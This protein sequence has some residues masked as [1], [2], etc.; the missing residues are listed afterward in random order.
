MEPVSQHP[1]EDCNTNSRD[2]TI[3]TSSSNQ[4]LAFI[5]DVKLTAENFTIIGKQITWLILDK[6]IADEWKQ[7]L[8][9]VADLREV[10]EL[11]ITR[12][13]LRDEHLQPLEK[14]VH[15]RKLVLGMILL[16]QTVIN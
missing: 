6:C 4:I 2:V 11:S 10:T 1:N 8:G 5:I 13:G 14:M 16:I 12:C 3:V 15:L 7:I 9:I